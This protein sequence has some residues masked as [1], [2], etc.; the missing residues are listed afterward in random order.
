[1]MVHSRGTW[2]SGLVILLS[3]NVPGRKVFNEVNGRSTSSFG[4]R[5]MSEYGGLEIS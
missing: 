3:E 5:D 1:M 4:S 2:S